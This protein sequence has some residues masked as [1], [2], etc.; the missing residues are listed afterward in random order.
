MARVLNPPSTVWASD[1]L[2]QAPTRPASGTAVLGT[3]PALDTW[4]A[5]RRY[6]LI[7]GVDRAPATPLPVTVDEATPV[8]AAL[9]EDSLRVVAEILAAT[10]ARRARP[11]PLLLALALAAAADDDLTRRA[12]LTALPRVARTS[13]DLFLFATSVQSLRGWGRGLRRAIGAWY[14]DR[15]PADLTGDVLTTPAHAGWRHADLLRLGHP[16][17]PTL[18]HDAIYRWLVT[19]AEPRFAGTDPAEPRS[20]QLLARLAAAT[21]IVDLRDAT[22]AAALIATHRLPLASVPDHLRREPPVWSAILPHLPITALL[23]ALP[24]LGGLGCLVPGTPT[25]DLIR[26]RLTDQGAVV[27][28]GVEPLAVVAALRAYEVGHSAASRW[29]VDPGILTALGRAFDSCCHDPA[30][31]DHSLRLSIPVT[32]ARQPDRI[33]ALSP[34]DVA[35]TLAVVL[36]RSE[37]DTRIEVRGAATLPLR[38]V[39]GAGIDAAVAAIGRLAARAGP[40]AGDAPAMTLSARVGETRRVVRFGSGEQGS[41]RGPIGDPDTDTITVQGI[42]TSLLATVLGLMRS[43]A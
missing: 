28:A 8:R 22:V 33:G 32:I 7:G 37:S 23:A 34:L 10:A 29:D 6:L 25:H 39:P 20:A 5:L 17:A 11:E 31:G 27:C 42:D 18:T 12:A 13:R 24:D 26:E 36:S 35:A 41:G 19:G 2:E 15:S 16:K 38:L 30:M 40:D 21:A 3:R 43:S 1:P 9:A 14:N 4:Q